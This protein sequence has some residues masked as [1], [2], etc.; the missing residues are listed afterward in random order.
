[1]SANMGLQ[2]HFVEVNRFYP[3]ADT[4]RE[5][6]PVSVGDL[7]SFWFPHDTKHGSIGEVV[8]IEKVNGRIVHSLKK[9]GEKHQ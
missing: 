1:M 2:V 9:V 4:G 5:R 6:R 7:V 3:L 8:R